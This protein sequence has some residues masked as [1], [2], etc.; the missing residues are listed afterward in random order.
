MGACFT[1]SAEIITI[2]EFKDVFIPILVKELKETI[3]PKI[4]VELQM[5]ED[6]LNLKSDEYSK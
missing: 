3:I 1:K 2:N 4:I 5:T 6:R